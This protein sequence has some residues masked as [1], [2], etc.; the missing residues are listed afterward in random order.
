MP[1]SLLSI[2]AWYCIP[3]SVFSVVGAMQAAVLDDFE[4]GLGNNIV[5][6][7]LADFGWVGASREFVTSRGIDTPGGSRFAILLSGANVQAA[8]SFPVAGGA[9]GFYLEADIQHHFES[10]VSSISLGSGD[11]ADPVLGPQFGIIGS[12]TG[13]LIFFAFVRAAGD[14]PTSVSK[15]PIGVSARLRL[16]VDASGFDGDGAGFVFASPAFRDGEFRALEGLQNVRLGLRRPGARPASSWNVVHLQLDTFTKVDNIASGNVRIARLRGFEVTQSMQDLYNQIPL[17]EGKPTYVRTYLEPAQGEGGFNVEVRLRGFRGGAELPGSPLERYL[18]NAP[19]EQEPFSLGQNVL[20]RRAEIAQSANFLLP[21]SWTSGQIRLQVET[22]STLE[23]DGEGG[24]C[25]VFVQFVPAPNLRVR[26][27][28]I[29]AQAQF[30]DAR[31]QPGEIIGLADRFAAMYPVKT[32]DWIIDA[33][34][35]F[36]IADMQTRGLGDVLQGLRRR[37]VANADSST[38]IYFA[39]IPRLPDVGGKASE[40]GHA[41]AT[42]GFFAN[43]PY[44]SRT[45]EHEL[46]H[47]LGRPHSIDQSLGVTGGTLHGHCN[48]DAPIGTEDFPFIE[49]TASGAVRPTFGPLLRGASNLMFGLNHR[50][51]ISSRRGNFKEPVLDPEKNFELMSYCDFLSRTEVWPS[52]HT[53]SNL[54]AAIRQRFGGVGASSLRMLAAGA[55]GD[56]LL[57]SGTINVTNLSTTLD[58]VLRLPSV[59]FNSVPSPYLCRLLDGAGNLLSE[60]AFAPHADGD[61]SSVQGFALAI[62]FAAAARQ[63]AIVKNG[64]VLASRAASAN[65]PSVQLVTPNGGEVLSS[66]TVQITWIAS[67]SDSDSDSLVYALQYSADAGVSWTSLADKLTANSYAVSTA[68][69]PAT[70]N[71]RFRI[72]ASDGFNTAID[73][74]DGVFQIP[75]H[76]PEL[77]IGSPGDGEA[78]F[79]GSLIAFEAIAHDPDD[80]LLETVEWRSDVQGVLGMGTRLELFGS[81]L[82]PGDHT[83]TVTARDTS[84]TAAT[85]S[86][87]I[88]V[89]A[90]APPW[91][92]AT[93]ADADTLHLEIGA[94]TGSRLT[95]ETSSNLINWVSWQ[96]VDQGS[97]TLNLSD[98]ILLGAPR[99]YRA[100]TEAPPTAFLQQPASTAA[101]VGNRVVLNPQLRGHRLHFQWFYNG[102]PMTNATNSMLVLNDAQRADSGHYYVVVSNYTGAI[103]SSVALVTVMSAIYE[104]VHHFGTNSQD[105]INGWGPLTLGSDGWLYGCARNGAISNSGVIFKMQL[106]GA[107]YT[108]LHRFQPVTD[109]ANALGGV[110]EGSDGLLYGTCAVGGTN[111]SGTIFRLERDGTGFTVLRHLLS[112]GDCRNPQGALLEAADGMLYGTAYNGGGFARGGVFRLNKNGSAYQIISGF[113]FAGTFAPRGPLGGVIEAADGT[114]FG[115]TELGGSTNKGAVFRLSK[116]GSAQMLLASLGTVEG[117]LVSPDG[118]LLLANDGL[119]YS[120][121]YSGGASNLGG[122]FR[123]ATNGASFAII[124]HFGDTIGDGLEPRAGLIQ[125]PNGQIAGTTRIGGAANQGAVFTLNRNGANYLTRR[126]FTGADGARSRSPLLLTPGNV[127]YGMTF[128]G[129]TSDQGVIYR[130]LLL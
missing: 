56:S 80:G 7:P 37:R 79:G 103:T 88:R 91:L 22:D 87:L 116:D 126:S 9:P 40:D 33:P 48:E 51:V 6:A 52:S 108:V 11:P 44:A 67:D 111:N 109:G 18:I 121:A 24:A 65:P 119:L 58:P 74:S 73:V 8:K 89:F 122:I 72:F 81:Q 102:L 71:G 13:E 15:D 29:I 27:V 118:N 2:H 76:A 20:D 115:T 46:G 107:G 86:R 38:D 36:T 64:Q 68:A 17:V 96:T 124:K 92:R 113:N 69:L 93:V 26:F 125:L 41:A 49:P 130:F 43:L 28:P 32:I 77:V 104:V 35:T 129:G 112:T 60:T 127:V 98:T 59:P 34:M 25:G 100:R 45:A 19:G 10:F 94:A 99:F 47:A 39:A 16:V 42:V 61:A 50:Y 106:D 23:C 123:M 97:N 114:L 70:T 84:G 120:C 62:P 30:G 90:F 66:E 5:S 55:M 128:G 3:L 85:E 110:I 82:A 14:G 12:E 57:I 101:F 31:L 63:I 21:E 4:Y 95:V 117:G 83:I 53:C 1:R 75:N 54:L 105:G 78:Y